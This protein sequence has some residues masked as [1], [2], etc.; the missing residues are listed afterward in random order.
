M[1]VGDRDLDGLIATDPPLDKE[2]VVDRAT[3]V[4]VETVFVRVVEPLQGEVF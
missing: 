1:W 3:V 4:A 2:L